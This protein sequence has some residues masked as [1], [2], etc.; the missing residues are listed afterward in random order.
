MS[1]THE[2]AKNICLLSR[3]HVCQS[4]ITEYCSDCDKDICEA[5]HKDDEDELEIEDNKKLAAG[6]KQWELNTDR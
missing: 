4:D 6:E 3:C 1:I 2:Y 5:C